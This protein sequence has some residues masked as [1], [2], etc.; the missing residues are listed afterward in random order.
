VGLR[1]GSVLVPQPRGQVDAAEQQPEP[2]PQ[3]IQTQT[4]G[5]QNRQLQQ[6]LA[7]EE[8]RIAP[9]QFRVSLAE[10]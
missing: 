1:H 5:N 4:P 6:R 8:Q 9:A 2:H 3:L 10:E 7:R